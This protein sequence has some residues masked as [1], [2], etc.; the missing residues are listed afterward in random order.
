MRK[1]LVILLLIGFGY[2]F[3]S[4]VVMFSFGEHYKGVSNHYVKYG[5]E[6][7]RGS[8]LVTSIVVNYRGFDTLGEVTVLFLAVSGLALL[9][10]T[11]RC[12]RRFRRI[13]ASMILK[14]SV[15]ILYPLIILF[16]VYIFV[17]GHLTPGGGFQGGAVIAS[18]AMLMYLASRQY[19]SP[20]KRLS[21]VETLAGLAF[22]IIGL[23]GLY[24]AKSFLANKVIPLGEWNRLFSAGLIPFIYVAV[25]LKVGS[26]LSSMIAD[27]M[28]TVKEEKE[29]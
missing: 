18:S 20:H 12:K 11:C 27:M 24:Y 29:E 2:I 13:K 10:A 22:V 16:G 9:L 1:F 7:N 21:I 8:N 23:L 17:H 28:V 14:T 26:E 19:K 3:Y 6:E 5:I 25:G 4:A 15:N